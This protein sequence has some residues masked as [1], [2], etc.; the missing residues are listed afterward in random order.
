MTTFIVLASALLFLA[1]IWLIIAWGGKTIRPP[2][3]VEPPN[4]KAARSSALRRYLWWANLWCFAALIS[5]LLVAWAGGRLVMRVLAETSPASAQG[6]LT[7][8][9]ANVGVPTLE[10][11]LALL[12]FGGMPTGFIAALVY[13]AIYRWLPSG[14]LSG[15]LAGLLG[16][17]IFGAILEPFRTNNID[18]AIV[19]PGWLSVLLFTVLGIL[20]GALVAAAAGWYSHRLPLPSRRT[21]PAYLPLLTTVA[22]PPAAVLILVGALVVMAWSAA[23]PRHHGR[24]SLRYVWAGRTLLGLAVLVALP[25]FI[26]SVVFIVSV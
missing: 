14:R 11:T 3:Y 9:Q 15:P 7:E 2:D 6:A 5:G 4:R 17:L 10:G 21:V 13:L 12:L 19:G 23:V 20:Q 22:F 8:A 18:F 26:T 1:G 24:V 25:A 16:L